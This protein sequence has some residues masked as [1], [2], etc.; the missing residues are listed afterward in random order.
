MGQGGTPT[1]LHDSHQITQLQR[2]LKE[3]LTTAR[4]YVS[5]RPGRASSRTQSDGVTERESA[6]VRLLFDTTNL[7]IRTG[8]LNPAQKA[9]YNTFGNHAAPVPSRT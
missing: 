9:P 6:C 5:R 7:T 1:H 8:L 3:S 2:D 4:N